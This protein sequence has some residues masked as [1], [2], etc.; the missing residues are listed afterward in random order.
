MGMDV[1][2]SIRKSRDDLRRSGG[3]ARYLYISSETADF[4]CNS[5]RF[6]PGSIPL[7]IISNYCGL[8]IVIDDSLDIGIAYVGNFAEKTA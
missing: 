3:I 2:Q 4:L 5:L 8:E 6:V 1:F 7:N